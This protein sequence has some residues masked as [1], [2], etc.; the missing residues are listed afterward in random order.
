M[1][2]E[3]ASRLVGF[4]GEDGDDLKLTWG[5]AKL[6]WVETFSPQGTTQ[7]TLACC[8]L[9]N[10]ERGRYV[11]LEGHHGDTRWTALCSARGLTCV[12]LCPESGSL[13][14]LMQFC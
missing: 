1:F 6:Q 2:G 4:L 7:H 9:G 10:R 13:G 5:T 14:S 11:G 8:S 12:P 3:E